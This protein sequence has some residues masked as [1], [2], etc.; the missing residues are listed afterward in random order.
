MKMSKN[1]RRSILRQIVQKDRAIFPSYGQ[2][3]FLE[4]GPLNSK[5]CLV[6]KKEEKKRKTIRNSVPNE[7]IINDAT[8][9]MNADQRSTLLI[10]YTGYRTLES[11][12]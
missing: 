5:Q 7:C 12:G 3:R 11:D 2:N 10:P 1:M 8:Y 4:I 6:S 9:T